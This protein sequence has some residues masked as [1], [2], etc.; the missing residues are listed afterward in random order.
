MS[1]FQTSIIK[2]I[3]E[4]YACTEYS[5]YLFIIVPSPNLLGIV[6]I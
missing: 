6:K 1:F 2:F 4:Y 5:A 3:T